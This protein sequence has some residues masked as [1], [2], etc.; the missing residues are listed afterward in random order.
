MNY[1]LFVQPMHPVATEILGAAGIAAC[2]AGTAA[3]AGAVAVAT[4]NAGL[5]AAAM[6]AAPGLRVIGVHGIGTDAVDVTHATRLGIPVVNTPGANIQSVAEHAIALMLAVSKGFTAS[7]RAVRR[8]D[9][10]YKFS[11]RLLELHGRTLGIVGWGGIG[12]RTAALA[13]ALGMRVAVFSRSADPAGLE[14]FEACG[15]LDA[16]LE[17]ADVVSLHLALTSETRGIIDAAALAR[18]KP[19]AILVNTGRG[20]LVDE[21][22]LAEALRGGRL[23]GAGLDVFSAEP[24]QPDSPL[25]T[26][27]NVVLTPHTAGS[28]LEAQRRVAADMARQMVEVLAGRRPAHLVNPEVWDRR[29]G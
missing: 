28:T 19:D 14:G 21:A 16:L 11:A 7:Q 10:D 22:A 3:M 4:R 5:S 9:F 6:D 15:S 1:C 12:R 20:G 13:R 17:Q 23:F 2:P 8:G 24:L 25:L 29:R 18:M 26:L 27:D